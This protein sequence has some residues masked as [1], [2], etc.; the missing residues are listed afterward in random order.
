MVRFLVVIDTS[1]LNLAVFFLTFTE[2]QIDKPLTFDY[3]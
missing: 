3:D 2:W 1:K